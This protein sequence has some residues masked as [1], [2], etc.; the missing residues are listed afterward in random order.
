MWARKPN[1]TF[2][3]ISKVPKINLP[4]RAESSILAEPHLNDAKMALQANFTPTKA[5]SKIGKWD[6]SAPGYW[7]EMNDE[8]V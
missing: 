5:V 1:P 6:F 4:R 3:Q 7:I 2:R 8:Q